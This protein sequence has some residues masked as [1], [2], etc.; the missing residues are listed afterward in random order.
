MLPNRPLTDSDINNICCTLP[1]FRGVF[2]RNSLPKKPHK[3]ECGV[4]NLDDESGP[5]THW[6]AYNK[7]DKNV[8]YF[9]SFG[10]L[11]PPLEVIKYLGEKVQYNHDRY[12]NYNT[13]I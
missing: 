5:G 13:I 6:V 11:Q 1:H 7:R 4:I 3:R 2:M 8:I 12:Q 9:D 10:N